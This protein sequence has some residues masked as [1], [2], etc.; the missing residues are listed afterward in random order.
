MQTVWA[1]AGYVRQVPKEVSCRAK[2]AVGQGEATSTAIQ[3]KQ[4]VTG[5]ACAYPTPC[6][7]PGVFCLTLSAAGCIRLSV[8][9]P[10]AE[11]SCKFCS[12]FAF[13]LLPLQFDKVF[14]TDMRSI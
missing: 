11:L 7:I 14:G 8:T 6:S 10:S 12:F 13:V 1:L 5:Q 9:T 3:E 2:G 4:I